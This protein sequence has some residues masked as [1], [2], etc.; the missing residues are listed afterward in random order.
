MWIFPLRYRKMN[1]KGALLFGTTSPETLNRRGT[2]SGKTIKSN[3]ISCY[4]NIQYWRT[5]LTSSCW[6]QQDFRELFQGSPA[7]QT[8]RNGKELNV[9]CWVEAVGVSVN[10]HRCTL[11]RKDHYHSLSQLHWA[12]PWRK[13][14]PHS[15][16]TAMALRTAFPT[17][18]GKLRSKLLFGVARAL[19]QGGKGH[20]H[21]PP[22][23]APSH[24]L[25]ARLTNVHFAVLN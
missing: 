4:F 3:I 12:P 16:K 2:S 19:P 20:C 7:P 8:V 6:S 5:Y 21:T 23:S 14:K 10:G 1:N 24:F 22:V 17:G 13:R 18:S 11:Q 15:S 25:H 9:H